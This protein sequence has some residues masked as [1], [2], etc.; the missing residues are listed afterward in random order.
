[1]A[2]NQDKRKYILTGVD[3][4][5][6]QKGFKKKEFTFK[7]ETDKDLFQVI[8]LRLGPSWSITSGDISLEFGIFT[9][10]WHRFLNQWKMPSTIRTA[11]CE[12][13]D[14]YCSIV[15][16]GDKH[17]WFK[18]VDNLD[19]LTLDIINTIDK[20]ILPYLDKHRT[21]ADISV[22]YEKVGQNLGLPPRHKLSIAVMTLGMGDSE[23]GL[24]MIK[25]EFSSN[26]NNPYYQ[27]VYDKI[28]EEYQTAA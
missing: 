24:K 28:I 19:D 22:S 16:K 15:D 2:D 5:L 23:N 10:E 20:A 8:E 7:R 14:C 11:D 13:R 25:E 1:M 21:R 12:I 17:N 27:K 6:K 4:Y 3:K 26:K 9:D 18:L